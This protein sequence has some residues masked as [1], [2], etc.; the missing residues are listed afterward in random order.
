M[1]RGKREEG[2]G[3]EGEGGGD[4]EIRFSPQSKSFCVSLSISSVATKN[5]LLTNSLRSAFQNADA[6]KRTRNKNGTDRPKRTRRRTDRRTRRNE[7]LQTN[8][9]AEAPIQARKYT[10][11]RVISAA[12]QRLNSFDSTPGSLIIAHRPV[13]FA[14]RWF[15]IAAPT[16][17]NRESASEIP[18]RRPNEIGFAIGE[19]GA[20]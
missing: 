19:R 18:D 3:G 7:A 2:R 10:V 4:Q 5:S 12:N 11:T 20:T 1:E 8:T 15:P 13:L 9:Q 6:L 14:M 17:A 16:A